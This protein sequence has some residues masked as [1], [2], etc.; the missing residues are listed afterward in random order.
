MVD[1]E[2]CQSQKTGAVKMGWLKDLE[3][4]FGLSHAAIF[5]PGIAGL[6]QHAGFPSRKLSA[7]LQ[8]Q[9]RHGRYGVAHL[10]K[11]VATDWTGLSTQDTT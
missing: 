9:R 11:R 6:R 7:S 8:A 1:E 4:V 10:T 5:Q 3:Q 2:Y